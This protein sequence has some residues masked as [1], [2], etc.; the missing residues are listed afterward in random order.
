MKLET[1]VLIVVCVLAGMAVT[2]WLMML[3]LAGLAVPQV[4]L[5]LIPAVFVGYVIYRVVRERVGNAEEDH[6]DRMDH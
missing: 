3:L 4:L 6:Y 2:F 1:L 5:A